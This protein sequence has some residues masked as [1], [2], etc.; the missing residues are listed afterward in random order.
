VG[1]PPGRRPAVPCSHAAAGRRRAQPRAQWSRARG[2][3]TA[4]G[5]LT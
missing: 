5:C 3:G 1:C 4:P 2:G